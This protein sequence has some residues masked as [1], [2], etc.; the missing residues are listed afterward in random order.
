MKIRTSHVS[1][2]STDS[3]I[4]RNDYSIEQTAEFLKVLLDFYNEWSGENLEFGDAFRVPWRGTE[5]C[6]QLHKEFA[7]ELEREDIVGKVIIQGV[8]DNS[9]PYSLWDL[10]DRKFNTIRIH[11]G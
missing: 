11:L 1:N 2:S 9:V 6:Y 3:F 7:S 5:E 4:C 8:E 10:M